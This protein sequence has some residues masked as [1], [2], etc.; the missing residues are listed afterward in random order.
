IAFGDVKRGALAGVLVDLAVT[1]GQDLALLGLFL[2]GIGQDDPTRGGLLLLD[3]PY[4]Q[5]IAE[6]LELH[7]IRPPVEVFE[8]RRLALAC[9]ECQRGTDYS[10]RAE[11]FKANLALRC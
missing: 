5:A 9:T 2:G 1:H 4:D 3:G 7:V 6:G 10:L 8:L 11:R